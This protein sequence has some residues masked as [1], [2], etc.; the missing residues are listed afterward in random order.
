[1]DTLSANKEINVEQRT[2][3]KELDQATT[4]HSIVDLQSEELEKLQPQDILKRFATY[5]IEKGW[6]QELLRKVIKEVR[7]VSQ[8][9][10]TKAIEAIADVITN[11]ADSQPTFVTT[12]FFGKSGTRIA[13]SEE[14]ASIRK[15]IDDG[16]LLGMALTAEELQEKAEAIPDGATVYIYDD[17]SYS[18]GHIKFTIEALQKMK[19]NLKIVVVVSMLSQKAN[20][21]LKTYGADQVLTVYKASTPHDVFSDE[22]KQKLTEYY[23]DSVRQHWDD[24]TY[25]VLSN[26]VPDN[27]FKPFHSAA[28]SYFIS[29]EAG[30]GQV[31]LLRS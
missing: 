2:T 13:E 1:M 22:D 23:G 24:G 27:F 26:K 25:T 10:Y 3:L 28:P 20:D 6:D 7:V 9:D 30:Y 18:G 15:S 21:N 31:T 11:S 8:E 4:P 14:F 12:A 17:A 5:W 16:K 29:D 19:K